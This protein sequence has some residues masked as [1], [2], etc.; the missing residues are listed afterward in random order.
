M[1]TAGDRSARRSAEHF[2][3]M[4]VSAAALAATSAMISA[5]SRLSPTGGY[6]DP[7]LPVCPFRGLRGAAV[8]G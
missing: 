2:K 7:D 3:P 6:F 4:T 8:S 1:L 5:R